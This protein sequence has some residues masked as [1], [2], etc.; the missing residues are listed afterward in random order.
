MLVTTYN[1]R[2]CRTA[3]DKALHYHLHYTF[4]KPTK[5]LGNVKMTNKEEGRMKGKR[6]E[7]KG[8]EKQRKNK[9]MKG[10]EARSKR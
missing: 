7:K 6:N 8:N 10:R 1:A 9:R 2:E 4:N 5:E 3:G